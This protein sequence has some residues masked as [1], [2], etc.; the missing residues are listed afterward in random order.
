LFSIFRDDTGIRYQVREHKNVIGNQ[1]NPN[2]VLYKH[3]GIQMKNEVPGQETINSHSVALNKDRF[4]FYQPV[5]HFVLLSIITFGIYDIYWYYRNWKNLRS[6]KNL[7]FSAVW[8]TVG[9]CIPILNLFLIYHAHKQYRNLVNEEGIQRDIYPGII[10]MVIIISTGLTNLP[11][12]YWLLCFVGTIP[13]AIVQSVLNELWIKVQPEHI[14]RT[15]LHGR[16]IF[17][18]V[19]G[20]IVW[21]L[22]I[23]GMILPD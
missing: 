10:V 20:G 9:L 4:S 14:H 5:W 3:G 1:R 13:L 8:R 2:I 19:V 22:A 21:F 6:F 23:L 12:P 16:Q 17:L 18:I 11:D 7:N 15:K